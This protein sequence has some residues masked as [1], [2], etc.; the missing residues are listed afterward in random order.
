MSLLGTLG[1]IAQVALPIMFPG[2][3]GAIGSALGGLAGSLDAPTAMPGAGFAPF[4]FPGIID[5]GFGKQSPIG[6]L[7]EGL[8]GPPAPA[9]KKKY[10]RIN[11]CNSKALTRALRRVEAYDSLRKRVDKSIRKAC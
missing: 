10:R 9:K 6:Q 4:Q 3:G 11:P 8:V 1:S 2:V 5:A 7:T